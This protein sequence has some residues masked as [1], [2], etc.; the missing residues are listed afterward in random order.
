MAGNK[1]PG[2]DIIKNNIRCIYASSNLVIQTLIREIEQHFSLN[3][4]AGA[5]QKSEA[6]KAENST[7]PALPSSKTTASSPIR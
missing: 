3:F 6:G 7:L 2:S 4:R 1:W 5:M